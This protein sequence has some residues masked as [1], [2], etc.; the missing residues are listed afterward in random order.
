MRIIRASPAGQ[1]RD[2][3]E[4]AEVGEGPH[5]DL[6][7]ASCS[8]IVASAISPIGMFGG[9]RD[10]MPWPRQP[11]VTTACPLWTSLVGIDEVEDEVAPG[12]RR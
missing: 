1:D 8:T 5:V 11:A 9:K 4:V 3:V 12:R 7:L 2:L 6:L 10:S